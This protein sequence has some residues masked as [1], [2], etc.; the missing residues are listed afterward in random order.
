MPKLFQRPL[1]KNAAGAVERISLLALVAS[2]LVEFATGVLLAEDYPSKFNLD[3][4]SLLRRLGIRD[5]IR[6]T[7]LHQASGDAPRVPRT[8]R[9]EAP[10]AGHG[11]RPSPSRRTME[12]LSLSTRPL[13]R[14][15]AVACSPW[16]AARL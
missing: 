6:P 12:G 2:V 15:A 5:A 4:D 11:V 8:R 13:R 10:D 3:A 9:P 7:C 16:S 14:S 1:I